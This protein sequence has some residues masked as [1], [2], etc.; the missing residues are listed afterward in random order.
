[1]AFLASVN[2]II[3]PAE[4]ARVSVLHN[5]FAF[6]DSVYG[7]S[8]ACARR[9]PAWRSGSRPRTSRCSPRWTPC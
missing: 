8:G 4:Q 9:P 3:T 7:T 1:M 6:G 2:G 5:G